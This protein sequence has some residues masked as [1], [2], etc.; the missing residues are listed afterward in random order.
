MK[1][2]S[3]NEFE[4][5]II[6]AVKAGIDDHARRVR[7]AKN[8][9]PLKSRRNLTILQKMINKVDDLLL[10]CPADPYGYVINHLMTIRFRL[11][12]AHYGLKS[13]R[14]Q[15]AADKARKARFG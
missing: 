8:Q 7:Q 3:R 13:P 11:Y 9:W 4:K 10:L 12:W 5:E 2:S 6:Q 15:K 1:K 14:K